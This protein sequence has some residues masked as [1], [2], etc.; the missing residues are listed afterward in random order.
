[1]K[2]FFSY[3][4]I[5]V[6]LSLMVGC[7]QQEKKNAILPPVR[8]GSGI[9]YMQL[10]RQHTVE[11]AFEEAYAV[12]RVKIGDWLGENT[13][14]ELS[15]FKAVVMEEFKGDLPQS[16]ALIQDG[17]STATQVGYPLFTAGNELLLFLH[18][19]TGEEDYQP[20]YWIVG[21]FT[22]FMDV[23]YDAEGNRYYTDRYGLLCKN[24]FG[25]PNYTYNSTIGE[26]LQIEQSVR[27][28]LISVDPYYE[29]MGYKFPKIYRGTDLENYLRGL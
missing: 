19:A 29:I 1:M 2:R 9:M 5:V 22:T 28:Y 17:C 14:H 23:A 4:L 11:S 13:E 8:V 12:A 7:S 20:A 21:A 3:L 26:E 15:Y 6:L 27:S 24:F 18:K 10:E 25:C 16:F